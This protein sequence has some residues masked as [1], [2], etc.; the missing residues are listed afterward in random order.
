MADNDLDLISE[1]D[2]TRNGGQPAL[3]RVRLV[4]HQTDIGLWEPSPWCVSENLWS[5][6]K[7]TAAAGTD[8]QFDNAL[9][10]AFG[11]AWTTNLLGR[12][13]GRAL[14]RYALT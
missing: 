14:A 1:I 8:Q 7:A 3:R 13:D 2:H 9:V 10:A 4:L 11:S 12:P 5:A 6:A